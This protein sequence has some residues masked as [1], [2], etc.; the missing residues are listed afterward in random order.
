M[1][2]KLSIII[3]TYNRLNYLKKTLGD[4]KSQLNDDME[5]I[6]Y[7]NKSK[8]ET[9]K[10]YNHIKKDKNFK[11]L[12]FFFQKKNV[13]PIKNLYDSMEKAK[14]DYVLILS[15]DDKV[16][17]GFIDRVFKLI[18]E[19]PEVGVFL[20]KKNFPQKKNKFRYS[21]VPKGKQAVYKCFVHTA[22]LPGTIYKRK[23]LKKG[24]LKKLKITNLYPQLYYIA[25][26]AEKYDVML[27][28]YDKQILMARNSNKLK[29]KQIAKYN[30]ERGLDHG[31][32]MKNEV[33][34]NLYD[35]KNFDYF[36]KEILLF[37]NNRWFFI[38]CLSFLKLGKKKFLKENFIP[39]YLESDQIN[40]SASFYYFWTI[41]FFKNKIFRIFFKKI[42]FLFFKN[43]L[44][45]KLFLGAIDLILISL[46]LKGLSSK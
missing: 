20:H 29:K 13:G 19:F 6:V 18:N 2:N 21:L 25:K 12:N 33:V 8:D 3:P 30:D 23:Y 34:K 14:H 38:K 4:L 22:S 40:S 31:L 11:D 16:E 39:T 44:N 26:I 24:Y 15:D 27:V 32:L 17:I 43:L 5:I 42:I 7:V 45:Y 46:K 9:R 35:D 36:D 10:Y 41:L 28:T 1:N 37:H